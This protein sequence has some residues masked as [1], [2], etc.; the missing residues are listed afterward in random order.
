MN[1]HNQQNTAINW[2]PGHMAKAKREIEEDLK[3]IDV[4]IEILDARI[5]YSSQNPSLQEIIKN[6]KKIILL[7][8]CDLANE[9]ITKKWQ[10]HFQN[11]GKEAVLINAN[12]GQGINKVITKI[13]EVMKEEIEKEKQKGRINKTIRVLVLRNTKCPENHH[14]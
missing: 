5:P 8:K 10:E 4:A 1:D 11:Q 6:K 3:L 2:F 7:N 14:L 9:Q 13:E 12:D